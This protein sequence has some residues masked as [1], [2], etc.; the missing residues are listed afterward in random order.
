MAIH[1]PD[2]LRFELNF[3]CFLFATAVA[4]HGCIVCQQ[5][6]SIT[7]GRSDTLFFEGQSSL[8]KSFGFTIVAASAIE[9][10][11]IIEDADDVVFA[12]QHLQKDVYDMDSTIAFLQGSNPMT[13]TIT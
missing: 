10:S 9:S 4:Q 12:F 5:H 8:I 13:Q 11:E 7:M 2:V 6:G 3:G 1:V